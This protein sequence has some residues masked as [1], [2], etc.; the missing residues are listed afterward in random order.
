MGFWVFLAF[1]VASRWCVLI[2]VSC[3]VWLTVLLKVKGVT[4]KKKKKKKKK[5]DLILKLKMG[6]TVKKQKGKVVCVRI[7]LTGREW[8]RIH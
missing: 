6:L 7:V 4:K 3:S 1:A 2:L 5:G 8:E